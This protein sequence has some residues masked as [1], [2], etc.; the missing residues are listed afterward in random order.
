MTTDSIR[1]ES[2]L[3]FAPT[4]A[5]INGKFN[6]MVFLDA[7]NT[8]HVFSLDDPH[9]EA[10]WGAFFGKL[11]Y[12]GSDEKKW[13]WRSTGGSDDFEPKPR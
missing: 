5:V 12:E 10:G 7:K 1:W 2:S 9:P 3:R 8:L 4:K 11:Y 13:E 6:R